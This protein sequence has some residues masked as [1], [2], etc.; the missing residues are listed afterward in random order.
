MFLDNVVK[1]KGVDSLKE[2]KTCQRATPIPSA[3]F[4]V[5]FILVH[6]I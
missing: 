3:I 6:C 1:S 5:L 4:N 2:L